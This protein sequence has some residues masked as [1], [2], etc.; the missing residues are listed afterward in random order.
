MSKWSRIGLIGAAVALLAALA[1]TAWRSPAA[2]DLP[3]ECAENARLP[4]IRPDYA[5]IVIPPNIAPLNFLVEEPGVEY[6]VRIHG[7]AEENGVEIVI[8]SRGPK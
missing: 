5:G 7:A 4:R 6:R 8:G 3:T 1:F 2:R